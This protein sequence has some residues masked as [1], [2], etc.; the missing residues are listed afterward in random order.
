M[1]NGSSNIGLGDAGILTSS[2]YFDEK[3][4]EEKQGNS[5]KPDK[6]FTPCAEIQNYD[7]EM[8]RVLFFIRGKKEDIVKKISCS[9]AGME[10]PHGNDL[11]TKN[12][13]RLLLESKLQGVGFAQQR[14][15]TRDL[16]SQRRAMVTVLKSGR[17]DID[18][19]AYD[20]KTSISMGDDCVWR[21]P[22]DH[23]GVKVAF[24]QIQSYDEAKKEY[25]KI[26]NE[27]YQEIFE[28][29]TTNKFT[30]RLNEITR[31]TNTEE[32]QQLKLIRNMFLNHFITLIQSIGIDIS[33][34]EIKYTDVKNLTEYTATNIRHINSKASM[35]PQLLKDNLKRMIIG[36]SLSTSKV[37]NG[38]T[39]P[40][41]L[42]RYLI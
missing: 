9:L 14:L 25:M 31:K 20:P 17:T 42:S 35:I 4:F 37:S 6:Y 40:L 29:Y 23:G 10:R 36:R 32:E 2:W 16:I 27:M 30:E 11:E 26:G 15:S 7:V 8:K 28:Y 22:S 38:G 34:E 24:L 41:D 18:Y 33:T 3:C 19:L 1:N 12:R 39:I 5:S 13:H 21:I